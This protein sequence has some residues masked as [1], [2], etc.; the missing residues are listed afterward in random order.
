MPE[1][2]YVID[3]FTIQESWRLFRIIGEFV[4]G[5]EAL[6]DVFPAVSVFGSARVQESD[7]VYQTAREAGHFWLIGI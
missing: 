7:P 1:K 6:N 4:D 5:I 2:Q 3:T